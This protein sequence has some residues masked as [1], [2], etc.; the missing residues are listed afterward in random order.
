[1][2]YWSLDQLLLLKENVIAEKSVMISQSKK[3]ILMLSPSFSARDRIWSPRDQVRR[4]SAWLKWPH[5]S[6]PY[7][8]FY[9]GLFS[10][11]FSHARGAILRKTVYTERSPLV[12]ACST[13]CYSTYDFVS[14]WCYN[15]PR[16]IHG[17]PVTSPNLPLTI[18]SIMK[19]SKSKKGLAKLPV[20]QLAILAVCRFA[21]PIASTSVFPWVVPCP[22]ITLRLISD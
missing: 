15:V 5:K 8:T 9:P 2:I 1:M 13:L 6:Q 16:P 14:I 22:S 21:E 11:S 20:Q 4:T 18:H 19:K 17:I 12:L 7:Q 3:A 10:A